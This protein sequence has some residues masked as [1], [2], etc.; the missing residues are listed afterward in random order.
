[1]TLAQLE[2]AAHVPVEQQTEEQPEDGLPLS[3][4]AWDEERRQARLAGGA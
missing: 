2:R 1:M 4:W 3:D